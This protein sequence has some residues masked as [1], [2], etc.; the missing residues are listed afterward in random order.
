MSL[1]IWLMAI[2]PTEVCN[3]NYTHNVGNMWR[4]ANVYDALYNSDGKKALDIIPVLEKGIKH[5]QENPKEYEA[6][7]PE[8]GWGSYETALPWLIDF[9]Y[10]C[11][12]YPDAII[13]VCK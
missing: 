11:K 8:N 7:N 10:S 1:D 5:M 9:C 13:G 12:E 4:E 2:R 3:K 6:M